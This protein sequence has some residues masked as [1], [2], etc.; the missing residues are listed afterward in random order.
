MPLP[1][2]QSIMPLAPPLPL[3]LQCIPHCHAPST[4]IVLKSKVSQSTKVKSYQR[5]RKVFLISR[6]S[7]TAGVISSRPKSHKASSNQTYF[8]FTY[9]PRTLNIYTIYIWEWDM[10]ISQDFRYNS[11]RGEMRQRAIRYRAL[12]IWDWDRPETGALT[13]WVNIIYSGVSTY[14][15]LEHR[16]EKT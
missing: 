4:P 12:G 15:L 6:D 3:P 8:A 13:H 2:R 16:A 9:N 1:I 5:T 7:G 10:V 14:S 11:V